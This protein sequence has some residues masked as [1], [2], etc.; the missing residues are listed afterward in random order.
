MRTESVPSAATLETAA[1]L[2]RHTS[3]LIRRLRATRPANSPGLSRLGILARLHSDGPGT[4]S[5]LADYLGLQP[6]SMTRLLSTMESAGLISRQADRTDRRQIRIEMTAE[7]RRLL[8]HDLEQ[9]RERLALALNQVLTAAEMELLRIAAGLMD[10]VAA[11]IEAP[12]P[13]AEAGRTAG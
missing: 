10:H 4:A 9:R 6:Q 11:A 5:G 3:R 2:Y 7:G 12:A 1:L 8:L 13:S